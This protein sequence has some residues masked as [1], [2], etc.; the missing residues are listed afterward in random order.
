MTSKHLECEKLIKLLIYKADTV[1]FIPVSGWKGDNLVKKSE[2]MSWY[3]GKTLLEAFDDFTVEENPT[4]KVLFHTHSVSNHKTSIKNMITGA[5]KQCAVLVLSAVGET[6]TEAP[7]GQ[8]RE[9]LS[10]ELGVKQIIV[11]SIKW[12]TVTILDAFKADAKKVKN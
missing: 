12:M 11:P 8:A 6:D 7:G 4:G 2:N 9:Q 10:K 1:P 3:S 5:Q